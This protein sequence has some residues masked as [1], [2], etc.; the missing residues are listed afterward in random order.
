MTFELWSSHFCLNRLNRTLN[1]A[2]FYKSFLHPWDEL[3]HIC[4][5][6]TGEEGVHDEEHGDKERDDDEVSDDDPAVGLGKWELTLVSGG[7]LPASVIFL[8]SFIFIPAVN[9]LAR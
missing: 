7:F 9:V 5:R 4:L 2:L 6:L 3:V 8:G 1:L